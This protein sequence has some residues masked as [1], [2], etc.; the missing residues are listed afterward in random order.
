[1]NFFRHIY[2]KQLLVLERLCTF[3]SLPLSIAKILLVFISFFQYFIAFLFFLSF[4]LSIFIKTEAGTR[5]VTSTVQKL[6][7]LPKPAAIPEFAIKLDNLSFKDGI[8]L[9]NFALYDAKGLWLEIEYAHIDL[10]IYKLPLVLFHLNIDEVNISGLNY[11]RIPE[12][13]ES[14]KE[15]GWYVP[16]VVVPRPLGT[17]A[18]DN[19][20]V[21]N[22]FV[23]SEGMRLEQYPLDIYGDIRASA[24]LEHMQAVLVLNVTDKG[25]E[26]LGPDID[27]AY[28]NAKLLYRPQ[29]LTVMV[30]AV[31]NRWSNFFA[32]IG[33]VHL[34]AKAIIRA[35]E[36]GPSK[37]NPF[38]IEL[39]GSSSLNDIAWLQRG[40][41]PELKAFFSYDGEDVSFRDVS[42]KGEDFSLFVSTFGVNVPSKKFYP[43]SGQYDFQDLSVF[44]A[45]LGGKAR[46]NI[47]FGGDVKKMFTKTEL[48]SSDFFLHTDTMR[49]S[50]FKDTS[51]QAD[52][53]II[54]NEVDK[55]NPKY[56]SP[57]DI[58]GNI[59]WHSN[60][61]SIG[62]EISENPLDFKSKYTVDTENLTFVSPEILLKDMTITSPKFHLDLTTASALSLPIFNGDANIV[63]ESFAVLGEVVPL[64][65]KGSIDAAFRGNKKQEITMR[66]DFDS[67]SLYDMHVVDLGI[68]ASIT[69]FDRTMIGEIP[70]FEGHMT[71]AA[72][73]Y[74][75]VLPSVMPNRIYDKANIKF[76][77]SKNGIDLD[78]LTNGNVSLD[79]RGIYKLDNSQIDISELGLHYYP[80]RQSLN[81]ENPVSINFHD[82]LEISTF[83]MTAKGNR[84]SASLKAE[85]L[86]KKDRVLLNTDISFPLELL[87]PYLVDIPSGL[88]DIN[89][90]VSGQTKDPKGTVDI[91]LNNF[92]SSGEDAVFSLYGHVL[93][94]HIVW[95][96]GIELHGVR[97]FFSNGFIP[98]YFNPYPNLDFKK[99]MFAHMDWE[100]D[101]STYWGLVPLYQQQG[102]GKGMFDI[103]IDGLLGDPKI[104][105]SAYLTKARFEDTVLNYVI[106]DIDAEIQIIPDLLTLA[107]TARDGTALVRGRENNNAAFV[108]ATLKKDENTNEYI[109]DLKSALNTFS[110]IKSD[111]LTINVSGNITAKGNVLKPEVSGSVNVN[112]ASYII[113][114]DIAQSTT[115]RSLQN[116]T[117]IRNV[118]TPISTEIKPISLSYNPSFN[119][120]IA[121]PSVAQVNGFGLDSIWQGELT[122]VGDLVNPLLIGNLEA[123]EGTFELLGKDFTLGRSIIVFTGNMEM[124]I[125]NI[126]VERSNANIETTA[127]IAGSGSQMK[128]DFSSVPALPLDEIIAQTI[129]AKTLAELTQFEAIQVATYAGQMLAPTYNPLTMIASTRDALGLQ[130]L[131]LNSN[132]SFTTTSLDDDDD[133]SGMLNNITLEAGAYLSNQLYLGFERGV[134]DTAVRVELE[135]LPNINANARL[136]TDSSQ[137]G[138]LWKRNY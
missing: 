44:L 5:A 28:V 71:T 110:P 105:G 129:Y 1:M 111:D 69:E 81:L 107:S 14:E 13:L 109:L 115:V 97:E 54:V 122:L 138:I 30:E 128:I 136:G 31:D 87:K 42:A 56:Q 58:A 57:V 104:N 101:I 124:P 22:V 79:I 20:I 135:L 100:G 95:D 52:A 23:A 116:V 67:L 76:D 4:S 130:V 3:L 12:T 35:K 82:G 43:L 113:P 46:G 99:K 62:H 84:A 121:I 73:N 89:I 66:S 36:L 27:G 64:V 6:L 108:N 63:V 70:Y 55:E 51:I 10:A 78:I 2:N 39:E 133:E 11:Y 80:T 112:H 19:L 72:Y 38:T 47:E 41:A 137:A 50:T 45:T 40:I 7:T 126:V 94:N 123:S 127:T 83:E 26:M 85:T 24:I 120:N 29:E 15:H 91:H 119:I 17:L 114:Q 65:G 125:Y 77:Y 9:E 21:E 96:G 132:D 118:D 93:N 53:Q 37:E 74:F 60:I 90:A 8:K 103:N 32:H 102:S 48:L 25:L 134:K 75:G 49:I 88:L 16:N 68:L 131:R 117:Y 61:F 98:I 59:L 34:N 106:S 33:T 18:I 86:F 92:V